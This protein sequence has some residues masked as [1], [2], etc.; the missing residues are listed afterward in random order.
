MLFCLF[1]LRCAANAQRV[2]WSNTAP[3]QRTMGIYDSGGSLYSI[4]KPGLDR[5]SRITSDGLAGWAFD[6]LGS[7]EAVCLSADETRFAMI[8][9]SA[10]GYDIISDDV[11]R[12]SPPITFNFA[13][14]DQLLG[15]CALSD[16]GFMVAISF[17]GVIVCQM[18]NANLDLKAN[19]AL[20]EPPDPTGT[21]SLTADGHGHG[22]I[23]VSSYTWDS[24]NQIANETFA[25]HA[26]D[27]TGNELWSTNQ[28]ETSTNEF[29]SYPVT[30]QYD[31]V[32]DRLYAN[33]KGSGWR[34]NG[35]TGDFI[36]V[37]ILVNYAGLLKDGSYLSYADANGYRT[38]SRFASN[39]SLMTSTR[40]LPNIQFSRFDLS[41]EGTLCF[42]GSLVE[43]GFNNSRGVVGEL[44]MSGQLDWYIQTD[45][46]ISVI[47]AF[48]GLGARG[49]VGSGIADPF[50]G[51]YYNQAVFRV[52]GASLSLSAS[53]VWGPSEVTGTITLPTN[54]PRGGLLYAIETDDPLVY[55]NTP[56]KFN[57]G[58]ST[59][60]FALTVAGRSTAKLV[61]V[62]ARLGSGYVPYDLSVDGAG[63]QSLVLSP[64][65]V[66]GGTQVMGD[67][68]LNKTVPINTTVTMS[69]NNVN[70]VVSNVTVLANHNQVGTPVITHSVATDQSATITA[71]LN[72][73]TAT[74]A[75]QILAPR[76]ASFVLSAASVPGG[77]SVIGTI[78]LTS[79]P[80]LGGFDLAGSGTGAVIV[81]PA[82][83]AETYTTKTFVVQTTPVGTSTNGTVSVTLNG[84]TL[85]RNLTVLPPGVF[86]LVLTPA[87]LYGGTPSVGVVKLEGKAPAGGVAVALSSS[88][89]AAASVPNTVTV[90]AGSDATSFSITTVAAT[91]DATVTIT[92]VANGKAKTAT[93]LVRKVALLSM[94]LSPASVK[95][96]TS[97]VMIL[98]LTSPAPAGG[99]VVTLT[100]GAPIYAQ[101]P[102]TVTF[103]AGTSAKSL[104]VT[105]SAVT[106][107]KQVLLKAVYDGKTVQQTLTITP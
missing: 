53:N 95:G 68:T 93:L 43:S 1:L 85:T 17:N 19:F 16:G 66:Y 46:S 63:V 86:S 65:S 39:D 25:I 9:A 84:V 60:T 28:G 106:S 14:M 62:N 59:K 92:S 54:A 83:H 26:Y 51:P 70:A 2:V 89:A 72:G 73:T 35:L 88:N 103:P 58:E 4:T 101:V 91:T 44:R 69:S 55:C 50:T 87:A 15:I 6:F 74:A 97:T 49:L 77:T 104:T 78:K 29:G 10:G 56:V 33:V 24:I 30:I 11:N 27:L 5:V 67:V 45:T 80:P 79:V 3:V 75:V 96:G 31:Q 36:N 18:Y 82:I 64:P 38:L 8:I 34:F 90:A 81:P 21:V 12:L 41:S 37:P 61:R 98:K 40:L 71:Q 99:T 76:M 100:S 42:G 102:A 32:T 94:A 48:R 57:E 7:A 107:T 20:S 23:S 105:T 47:D 52:E 13:G 22:I